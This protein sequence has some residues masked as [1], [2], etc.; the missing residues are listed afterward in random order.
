M[1]EVQPKASKEIKLG[2]AVLNPVVLPGSTPSHRRAIVDLKIGKLVFKGLACEQQDGQEPN[3]T[4]PWQ[5]ELVEIPIKDDLKAINAKVFE[6]VG[7]V[8][9][10]LK[11]AD[12]KGRWANVA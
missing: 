8:L 6:K 1:N 2:I 4:M 12:N 3:I 9:T 10:N 5:T 7:A 11:H